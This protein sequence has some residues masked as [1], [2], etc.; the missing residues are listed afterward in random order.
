[1]NFATIT[2]TI[3]SS[4]YV[5]ILPLGDADSFNREF[6]RRTRGAY[7]D[8]SSLSGPIRHT[9]RDLPALPDSRR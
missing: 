8:Q 3:F 6:R 5:L 9:R 1:M 2:L 4:E 7:P